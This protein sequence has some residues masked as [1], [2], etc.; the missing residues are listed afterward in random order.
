ML[1]IGDTTALFEPA[2]LGASLPDGSPDEGVIVFVSG[3]S[4]PGLA[5]FQQALSVDEIFARET[6]PLKV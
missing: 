5:C 2:G 3:D 4:G 6:S 1:A